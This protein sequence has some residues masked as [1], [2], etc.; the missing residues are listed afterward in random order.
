MAGF[1]HGQSRAVTLAAALMLLLL[2]AGPPA[3]AQSEF[4]GIGIQFNLVDGIVRVDAPIDGS[5]AAKAGILAGD[6]ITNIDG[7]SVKGLSSDQA[8]D[9]IRGPANTTIK[10]TIVR[11][12][13]DKP[14]EMALV[15]GTVK[16][17]PVGPSKRNSEI[18]YDRPVLTIEPGM[19]TAPIFD[20]AVDA[21][22]HFAVTGAQ[23]K[24]VRIWSID[25]GKLLQ[26]I[27]VPAGSG[28]VGQ[29]YGVAISPDGNLVAAGGWTRTTDERDFAIYL[30]NRQSGEMFRRISGLPCVINHL[31]FSTNGRYLAA[32]LGCG[33][34]LRLYDRDNKW[35]EV[36]HDVNYDLDSHGA[37]FANDGRLATT[38]YDG[39]V[40]LYDR[41][42]A[43]IAVRKT[44][45]GHRP[46]GIAFSPDGNVVAIGYEDA[47]AVDL[48]DADSLEPMPG[49]ITDDLPA[50]VGLF[51]VAWSTDGEDLFASGKIVGNDGTM[52]VL[53]WPGKG[54]GKRRTISVGF[55]TV[56]SVR[57]LPRGRLLVA[58]ANPYLAVFEP[59]GTPRW[60]RDRPTADFIGQQSTLSASTDGMVV[61]FDF[62]QRGQFPL[63][64][65]LHTLSLDNDRPRDDI[66]R[67][68]K[69]S[70]LS[71][72]HW[73]N[74]HSPLLNDKPIELEPGET[75]RSLAIHLNGKHFVLGTDYWLIALEDL[76]RQPFSPSSRRL[77][78]RAAPSVVRAINTTG[79]G[80]IAVA[81]YGDGTIRWHR[82]D[83]GRELLALMV[84][85]DRQNWVAWTPEGFYAA[86]PGAYGV[87]RWHVNHGIDAAATTVPVSAIPKLRRPDALPLVLQELETARAL[88]VADVAAARHD[89]QI[90]TGTASPPGAR[91]HVL[92][93]G[94]SDYGEKAKHLGL[95]FASKDASD[96][97]NAIVNS[98]GGPGA[99]VGGLYAEVKPAVLTDDVATRQGIFDAL[100]AM[101]RNMAKTSNGEDLAVIMFSGHG[102]I[103]D[104]H[105]YLLPYGVDASTPSR[106]KGSAIAVSELQAELAEIAKY[107]RVLVLLDACHSGAATG[108]GEQLAPSADELRRTIVASNVTVLTSS[109]ANEV[110]REDP[111]W[112]NGAFTKVLLEAF[113]RAA[114]TD[115]NGVI[116]MSELTAYLSA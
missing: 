45:R 24:T 74:S 102:A 84:L 72:D 51:E 17:Q 116:S 90:A 54:H 71:I 96:V 98:E 62:E 87:L 11:K 86:T 28:F 111:K 3:W 58:T 37:A 65:D 114:D 29:I 91:L 92:T 89:V 64:F 100:D 30:F 60:A 83:D 14:I 106:L 95:K 82:M 10:L 7:E 21:D 109:S 2:F 40:R 44:K 38:A 105:M 103:V 68:P 33:Q 93:I 94:V 22:G 27:R 4:G 35:S 104:G 81:A 6:V 50:A 88:G 53:A 19:H 66:T 41:S 52:T 75:S 49:P 42:F 101:K 32:V 99:K 39:T 63:R 18:I 67:L 73:L 115:N 56:N 9:K 34:G 97:F 48:L 1:R 16:M 108:D 59:D 31:V 78:R 79:D 26:T 25:D 85:S 76:G 110:S 57:G 46:R 113:G 107:G 47:P 5:P 55:N 69:Q 36:F 61:D 112:T 20:A 80:R 43:L 70:G 77:W 15:R 23:D 13:Q 8:A 12:G